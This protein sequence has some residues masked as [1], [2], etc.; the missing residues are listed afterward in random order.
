M[1]YIKQLD[2]MRAIAILFVLCNHSLPKEHILFRISDRVSGPDV[3]FTISGFLITALLLKDRKALD[4]QQYRKRDVFRNF[5]LKRAFRIFP[6]YYLIVLLDCLLQGAPAADYRSYLNFTSNFVIY[7]NQQW[8][9]LSHL[10]TMAVEQQFYLLW[11]FAMVLMPRKW[12]LHTIIIFIAV[13]CY[14]RHVLPPSDFRHVLPQTCF[15][16]LGIGALLAWVIVEK[17][18]WF[19][20][21]YLGLCGLAVACAGL[22]VGKIAF[23]IHLPFLSQRTLVAVLVTWLIGY[24]VAHGDK[25]GGALGVVFNNKFLILIGKMSYGIYLYHLSILYMAFPLLTWLNRHLPFSENAAVS[26]RLLL[27]ECMTLIFV[28]AWCSWKYFEMPVNALSKRLVVPKK[29]EAAPVL[30][31]LEAVPPLLEGAVV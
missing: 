10:W 21:V 30:V 5:F 7:Q 1:K 13:G 6:A 8:G 15:N 29:K 3:F 26:H 20:K 12:L 11:P 24:F 28:L 23:A 31:T 14:S 2:A 16:A 25:E 19:G 27:A 9:R 22:M 18:E 17:P 4:L